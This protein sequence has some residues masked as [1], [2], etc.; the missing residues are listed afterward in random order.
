MNGEDTN[1]RKRKAR[2]HFSSTSSDSEA[3]QDDEKMDGHWHER[4]AALRA[5]RKKI[6]RSNRSKVKVNVHV[7]SS[8]GK[9]HSTY[10][11]EIS[12]KEA[13]RLSRRRAVELRNQFSKATR[14]RAERYRNM[15]IL[16]SIPGK[17]KQLS[18]CIYL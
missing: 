16:M 1:F 3:S 13:E 2:V 9:R 18:P 7:S 12:T 15:S 14:Q 5:K 17:L 4:F 10:S 11:A 8:N 6:K